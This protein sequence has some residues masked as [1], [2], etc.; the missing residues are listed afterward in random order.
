MFSYGH[1]CMPV[2]QLGIVMAYRSMNNLFGKYTHFDDCIN[3]E[4]QFN[5]L[6]HYNYKKKFPGKSS[7]HLLGLPRHDDVW[8]GRIWQS[9]ATSHS[10]L[11]IP[12]ESR[13][14]TIIKHLKR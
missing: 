13:N 8:P 12:N 7:F 2:A 5:A 11:N 3:R 6:L 14:V 1:K 10:K 9:Q 4:T